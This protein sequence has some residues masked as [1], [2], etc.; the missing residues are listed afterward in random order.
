M[1]GKLNTCEVTF[2]RQQAKTLVKV[3][4]KRF[5]KIRRLNQN[6]AEFFPASTSYYQ[7]NEKDSSI[8]TV[9]YR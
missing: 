6:I 8:I 3:T 2:K 5:I 7:K 1:Y 9:G 4:V